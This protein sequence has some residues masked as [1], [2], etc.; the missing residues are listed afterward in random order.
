MK[1][2]TFEEYLQE[3]FMSDYQGTDDDGPER[4]EHWM[5]NLGQED[6]IDLADKYAKVYVKNALNNIPH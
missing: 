6:L 4:F 3:V 1:N 5:E 2:E